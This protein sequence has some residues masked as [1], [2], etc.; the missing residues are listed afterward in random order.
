MDEL[1]GENRI[2][3][4]LQKRLLELT[5]NPPA[6]AKAAH[7]ELRV[8]R[9]ARAPVEI[10]AVI[11]R[12]A[13]YIV[14]RGVYCSCPH[15]QIRVIGMGIAEPCY[16]MVAVELAARTGRFHDLSEAIRGDELEDILLEAIAGGRSTTLR[17]VLY[18]IGGRREF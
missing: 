6:E 7:G 4:R 15:F 12:E 9:L 18:R 13:D 10:W 16:H 17:R 14:I 11:G 8:V 3:A 1:E 5:E 2:L